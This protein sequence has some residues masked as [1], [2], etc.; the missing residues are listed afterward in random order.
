MDTSSKALTTYKLKEDLSTKLSEINYDKLFLLMDTNTKKYCRSLLDGIENID[1]A[2]EIIIEAGEENKTIEAVMHIWSELEL[3]GAKRNSLFIN[4]GGGM[5]SDLGGFAASCYKRGI[6]YINIPTTLLAQVDAS[7]GGKTGFNMH[8]IKNQIGVFSLPEAVLVNPDF[9]KTLSKKNIISGYG[10]MLK[11]ALIHDE[12]YLEDLLTFDLDNVDYYDLGLLIS[13]SI[14]IKEYFVEQ[15]PKEENIRK[16]LNFGHSIG[17]AIESYSLM[18]NIDL[19][20]GEA[21][22]LGMISELYLSYLKKDFPEQKLKDITSKIKAIY[23]IFTTTDC[24]DELIEIMQH[25]KKNTSSKINFTLLIDIGNFEI[26]N[27]CEIK[28]I[29]E[30]LDY[31]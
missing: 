4:L 14:D 5:I 3:G 7:A 6:R 20:H 16:A 25:D 21:V 28:E 18:N 10:E 15:D 22:A 26:D 13:K 12:K 23:P 11:H 27:Y 2:Y 9:L 29:K 1:S 24:K 8:S 31:L 30:A 19:Y 17:H